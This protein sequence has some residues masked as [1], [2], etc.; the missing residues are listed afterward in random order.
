L[1]TLD[2]IITQTIAY[3]IKYNTGSKATD[4]YGGQRKG[5]A[6]HVCTWNG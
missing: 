2:S 4:V 6:H 1:R 3:S 5:F